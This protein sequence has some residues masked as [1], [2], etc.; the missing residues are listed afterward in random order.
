MSI[1]AG[2]VV[3]A[4]LVVGKTVEQREFE[5]KIWLKRLNVF[6]K[7][8]GVLVFFS[9]FVNSRHVRLGC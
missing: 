5:K 2:R 7:A 4:E 3:Y 1:S 6:T 9:N 8:R